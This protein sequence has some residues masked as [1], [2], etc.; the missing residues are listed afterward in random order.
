MEA[1]IVD[2]HLDYEQP[3]GDIENALLGSLKPRAPSTLTDPGN[4]DNPGNLGNLRQP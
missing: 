3:R 2:V 1:I 4:L